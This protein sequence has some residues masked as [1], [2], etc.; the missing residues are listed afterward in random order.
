MTVAGVV[1]E[2][3]RGARIRRTPFTASLHLDG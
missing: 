2:D 1:V 3:D